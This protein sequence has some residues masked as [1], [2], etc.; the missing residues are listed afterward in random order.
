MGL[1]EY[2]RIHFFYF[3]HH[4]LNTYSLLYL[5]EGDLRYV[6]TRSLELCIGELVTYIFVHHKFLNMVDSGSEKYW[7]QRW[8]E[9]RTGWDLGQV[10]PPL[11]DYFDTLANKSMRILIPGCGN[12]HEAAYLHGLGF[13]N[14]FLVDIASMPLE[15]FKRQFPDFPEEHLIHGDFFDLQ[16]KFDLIVEQTFFCAI[17]RNLREYYVQKMRELLNSGGR[18]V[19]LLFATEFAA[20]GPPHGGSEAEY[21]TLFS[22]H[23]ADCKILPCHNSIAPRQGNELFIEMK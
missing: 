4:G 16:G 11:K 3:V 12:A 5:P 9:G 2:S 23:F 15:N 1:P 14:V 6:S 7:T 8:Q 17:D 20:D 19:G 21:R 18:L 10:S 22:K 13:T